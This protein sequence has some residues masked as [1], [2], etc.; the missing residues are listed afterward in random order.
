M[1]CP[2]CQTIRQYYSRDP[3]KYAQAS[4]TCIYCGA[5]CIQR[6]QRKFRL[7]ADEKRIR[8]RAALSDWMQHGHDEQQLR[9]LAKSKT[10]A[11]APKEEA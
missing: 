3:W 1:T 9:G 2:C 11:V 7:P 8:C 6:I 5:R 10:W 4:L